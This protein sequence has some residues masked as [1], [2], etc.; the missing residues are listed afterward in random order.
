MLFAIHAYHVSFQEPPGECPEDDNILEEINELKLNKFIEDIVVCRIEHIMRQKITPEFWSRFSGRKT[1]IDGFERFKDAVDYLYASLANFLPIL[2]KLE[3]FR[4]ISGTHRVIY[5]EDTLLG[6]FKVIVTSTLLSQ[7]PLTHQIIT[8]DFYKVSFKV[9]C[10]ADKSD[11]GKSLKIFTFLTTFIVSH[12]HHPVTGNK[13]NPN[14]KWIL[15][16]FK[17]AYIRE[18]KENLTEYIRNKQQTL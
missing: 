14:L 17:W 3:K 15:I 4:S 1:E 13:L 7:L 9:F 12:L 18:V 16:L 8:E 5:G 10:N 2:V 11:A 6:T